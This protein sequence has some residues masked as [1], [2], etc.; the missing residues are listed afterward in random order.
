MWLGLLTR[1]WK[2]LAA[3]G[4]VLLLW[5][6]SLRLESKAF[7]RGYQQATS[8]NAQALA[9][10]TRKNAERVAT[11]EKRIAE[12]YRAKDLAEGQL[13]AIRARPPRRLVCHSAPDGSRNVPAA[14]GVSAP[15]PAGDGPLPEAAG[16]GFDPASALYQLVDEADDLTESCRALN[17]AVHG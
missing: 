15:D 12:A 13:A 8:E 4:A 3:V 14:A 1:Y 10:F 5:M 11:D 6:L 7:E 9:E 17:S 16:E 2:P